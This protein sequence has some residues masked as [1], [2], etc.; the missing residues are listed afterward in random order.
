MIFFC[1][2][3]AKFIALDYYPIIYNA[4]NKIGEIVSPD[5]VNASPKI[6]IRWCFF[7]K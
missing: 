3:V 1:R 5:F 6:S 4:E 2:L 7:K